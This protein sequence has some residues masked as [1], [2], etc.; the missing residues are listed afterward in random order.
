[1]EAATSPAVECSTGPEIGKKVNVPT[2]KV[3]NLNLADDPELHKTFRGSRV[4]SRGEEVNQAISA[5]FDPATLLCVVCE[6]EHSI[7]PTDDSEL[8]IIITDQNFVSAL[9]GKNCCVPIVRLED[10]S[11]KELFEI[12][13]EILDR[14]SL[15]NGTLFLVGSTSYLNEVG[16]TIY[17]MDWVR[18]CKDYNNRWRHVKVGP[19]PPTL[20]EPTAATTTKVL[21]EVWTWFNKVYGSSTSFPQAAWEV[22]ISALGDNTEQTLDLATRETYRVALPQSLHSTNLVS[23]KFTSS[24]CVPWT[25][26]ITGG[27]SDELLHALLTQL[28]PKFGCNAHP[29]VILAREPAEQ[30]GAMDTSSSTGQVIVCGGSNCKRLAALLTERGVSVTDLTVP[31]WTPTTSNISKLSSDIELLNLSPTSILISDLLSNVSF[32][33]EQLNGSLALPVKSGGIFHMY[34]R[35]SVSS[36]DSFHHVMEKLVPI[37]KSVPGMKICLPPLPRYLHN[38]CCLLDGHCEDLGDANYAP[39]LLEKTIGLRKTIRDFLHAA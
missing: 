29:E 19:L 9:S 10:P 33:Y 28:T 20:R 1:M 13:V 34:G 27:K 15:P 36:K 37:F 4:T 30:E 8:A 32:C 14:Q 24:S 38:P 21:V 6:K 39:E 26:P 25:L 16:S 22:V 5:T 23:H 12:S 31:G 11:L 35:V 18:M 2:E 7:I 3:G 17:S